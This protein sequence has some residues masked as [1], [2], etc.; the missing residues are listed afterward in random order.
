[1]ECILKLKFLNRYKIII[2]FLINKKKK[3]YSYTGW[4]I[5]YKKT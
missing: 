4:L 5:N 1:M 3:K 2:L